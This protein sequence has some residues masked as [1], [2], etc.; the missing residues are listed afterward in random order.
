MSE[1]SVQNLS[2]QYS[3]NLPVLAEVSFSV[4]AGQLVALCGRNGCGKSTLLSVMA[5]VSDL[6]LRVSGA[7]RLDGREVSA[8]KRRELAQNIAY[9]EQT[10]YST[11]NFL[12]RDYV[13][14]G[15]FAYSKN[16]YYSD[17]DDKICLEAISEVGIENLA[18]RNVHELSGGEFQKVRIARALA[19][20][21]K[22][23]LLDEPA[24]NLDFVYE[25]QLM[26]M[27]K[28]FCISKNIGIILSMHDVNLAARYADK[29]IFMPP[30]ASVIFGAPSDLLNG[31]NL[32]KTF[33]V[34]FTKASAAETFV[35]K[36]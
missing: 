35:P 36:L 16:G 20:Q 33:G 4:Q 21:P 2:A 5:G 23:M 3:Q 27:L 29:M 9:M 17:A 7:V 15:R 12:V 32:K 8:F 26:Q 31:E 10:E 11:W 19:Q 25:P 18:G 13:L 1:F 28:D 22:F 14:Q 34:D 30:A 24:A 6:G